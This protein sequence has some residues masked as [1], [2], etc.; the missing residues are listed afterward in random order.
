MSSFREAMADHLTLVE[1]RYGRPPVQAA[2]IVDVDVTWRE[3]E[4]GTDDY[5]DEYTR[6]P[7]LEVLISVRDRG[8]LR[9]DPGLCIE[10]LMRLAL[11]IEVTP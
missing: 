5:G 7:E 3:G 6:L 1:R 11:G 9:A 8:D 4:E 2:D 10:N